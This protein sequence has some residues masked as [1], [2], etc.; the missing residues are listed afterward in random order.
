MKTVLNIGEALGLFVAEEFGDL[1]NV[2]KFTKHSAGAEMN[3]AIGL[4]RLGYNSKFSTILGEDIIAN[5]IINLLNKEKVNTE[6]VYSNEKYLTGIM[7]KSKVQDGDPEISYNR[8][9]SAC[10]HYTLE[11]SQNIDFINIDLLHTTGI[12]M[13][14]SESACEVLFDLKEKAIKSGKIVTFDPN[15]RPMLWSSNEEMVKKINEFA[16]DC[17]YILPGISEGEILTGSS[18]PNAIA[19]FYIKLGV[20]NVI[21]KIGAKGAYYKTS[22]GS[23]GFVDGFKVSEVVDTVGAGDG[24]ATGVISGI[25]DG[26]D[27]IETCRRGCAI[28]AI[29]VT[30]KSDNEGLPTREELLNFMGRMD[31]KEG[32]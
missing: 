19:D 29:Q 25:N 24:F 28:G 11:Q 32:N 18:D 7:F 31:V 27:I 30:H 8:K 12:F 10:S 16:K 14:I 23:E 26:C 4:S 3:V 5:Y 6:Y 13:A 2:N 15:L 21:V 20:K 9:N 22:N 17:D 1:G